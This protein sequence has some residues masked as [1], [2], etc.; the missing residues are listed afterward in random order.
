[1]QKVSKIAVLALSGLFCI[2]LAPH[3][4]AQSSVTETIDFT[5]LTNGSFQTVGSQNMNGFNSFATGGTLNSVDFNVTVTQNSNFT[6]TNNTGSSVTGVP[7]ESIGSTF[8]EPGNSSLF[9]FSTAV[10]GSN[11]TVANGGST[12]V[13]GT[14]T[15]GPKDSGQ[16]S[17]SLASFESAYSIN[18]SGNPAENALGMTYSSNIAGSTGPSETVTGTVTYFYTAPVPELSSSIGLMALVLGG[19]ALGLRARR[20]ARA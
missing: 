13:T 6:L 12:T 18:S 4:G 16:I 15:D 1:M 7:S 3:A 17:S 5:A 11:V 10:F 20:R 2:A 19:G 9:G 14:S 8:A